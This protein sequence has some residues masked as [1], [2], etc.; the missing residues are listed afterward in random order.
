MD[1]KTKKPAT[2][3][4][5]EALP[6]GW[7]GEIIEDAL[8]ASPRPAFG[9]V[10]VTSVLGTDLGTAFDRGRNGPG[11]WWLIDEPELHLGR[12]ILVPDLAG[13]R[14]DKM[15]KPPAPSEPFVTLAPDWVCEVL[16]PSTAAHD[17]VRKLRVYARE[18]VAHAW[19]IDP[20]T[21]SLEVFRRT[22]EGWLLTGSFERDEV[23]RPEPF[24][25]L[26]LELAALWLPTESPA[27]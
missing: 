27:P 18:G 20:L 4:D 14:R 3:A 5:I 13:W 10:R 2:Y 19:L 26:P 8:Y 16:S 21:R 6:V 15:V 24:D 1:M 17:R 22:P 25:A 12:D 23:C 9:H 11:G 7:V